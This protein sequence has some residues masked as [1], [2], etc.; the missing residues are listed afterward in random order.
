M[1]QLTHSAN[2]SA[3]F[4]KCGR[5]KDCRANEVTYMGKHA[6]RA[7]IVEDNQDIMANLFT[8][9]EGKGY[10]LD[11]AYDGKQ[12]LC[13]AL[14][15]GFDVAVLDIMLPG[16]DGVTLCRKLREE[17]GSSVPVLMLTARDTEQ[18]K[19]SGL[20]SGADDYMVKPFS[21]QELDARLRAL[22][23]RAGNGAGL[24]SDGVL[25]WEGIELNPATHSV[26][27]D[28]KALKLS[29]AEFTI[30]HALLRAAPAVVSR[31]E[32]ERELWGETA[33]ESNALRIHI[34][35]L[36]RELDKPFGIPLIRTVPHV[37]YALTRKEEQN[38]QN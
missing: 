9:L 5:V 19:I 15:G 38:V 23:R 25:Q 2:K 30:L 3:G 10:E 18:D 6:I 21:L 4:Q 16:M 17:H 31:G 8:F 12:G 35:S 32:L 14:S 7:L 26:A 33:P 13:L 24:R 1:T 11:C 29:P 34:H 37:G 28:G 27:R 36:R 22:V 20:D